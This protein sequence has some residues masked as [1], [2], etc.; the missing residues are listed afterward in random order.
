MKNIILLSVIFLL[1]P[2]LGKAATLSL[3]PAIGSFEIGQIFQVAIRLDT[4]GVKTAGVDIHYLN[5]NPQLLEVQ[6]ADSATPG[7][8]IEPGHLFANTVANSVN[9]SLGKIDFSQISAGGTTFQG[10]GVLATLTLKSLAGGQANLNFDFIL[11]STADTNVAINGQDVLTSVREGSYTLPFSFPQA[12]QNQINSINDFLFYSA[13]AIALIM[14]LIAAFLFITS[15]GDVKRIN[16]AKKIIL[17]A[18]IGLTITL[19]AK[20]LVAVFQQILFG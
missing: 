7:I 16:T 12:V 10:E 11:N 19:T 13:L 8:Q 17:Y 3:D 14:I 1:I 2:V 18:C 5:Y 4:Q 20:V 6:D 9:P 15:G